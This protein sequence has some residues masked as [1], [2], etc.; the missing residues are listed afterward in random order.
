MPFQNCKVI[1]VVS[2]NKTSKGKV[3]CREIIILAYWKDIR[4]EALWLLS[5]IEE[6]VGRNSDLTAFSGEKIQLLEDLKF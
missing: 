2:Y 1:M 6:E 4:I 3:K 5:D